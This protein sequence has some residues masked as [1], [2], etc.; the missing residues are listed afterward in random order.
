[1]EKLFCEYMRTVMEEMEKPR[2]TTDIKEF[3]LDV[4]TELVFETR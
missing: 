1:M 3:S 4:S 2:T